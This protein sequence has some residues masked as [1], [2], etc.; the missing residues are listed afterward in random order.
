M[1]AATTQ[2]VE[3]VVKS[4]RVKATAKRA[5]EVFTVNAARWWPEGHSI[6]STKSPIKTIVIEPRGGGRWYEIGQDGSQCE[7]GKVVA[8]EPPKRVVLEWQINTDWVFDE[9]LHTEVEVTF[10]QDGDETLVTLEHRFLER[11]GAKAVETRNMIDSEGGWGKT[12]KCY[13]AVV[14]VE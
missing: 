14:N 10:A 11:M 5:F 13:A 9:S 7:W 1:N 3:P 6:N 8:W 2:Y 12:L 4:I